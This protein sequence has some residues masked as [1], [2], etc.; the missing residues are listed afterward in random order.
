M[1]SFN[2]HVNIDIVKAYREV[3]SMRNKFLIGMAALFIPFIS[4]FAANPVTPLDAKINNTLSEHYNDFKD[5][6]YFSGIALA[7][8]MPGQPTK[9]YYIGNVG[10]ESD[11]KKMDA[12]TL[13]EIGSIT[14]S[15]TAAIILQLEKENKLH[16]SDKIGDHLPEYDKW[17]GLKIESLL[18]M[19]TGLPNYTDSPL[20]NAE[21]YKNMQKAWTDKE[22]IQYAYPAGTFSPPLR[23][24][25]FYCIYCN[26]G[27][28][29]TA[30][31]IEK[32]TKN[33]FQSEI[34]NRLIKAAKLEN[35]FYPFPA[36]NA[37]VQA[38]LAHGY[39]YNPYA[40]P[41]LVG[42]DM[43]DNNLSWAGAA[44][45]VIS[46]PEDV[47]K[48]V[49]ALFVGNN[50][51]NVE[52][53]SKLTRLNSTETGLPIKITSNDEPR[54]FGLGVVQGFDKTVGNF[55]F[56]EGETTGFRA[57]YMYVPSNGIIISAIFNSA[58]DTE[59]DHAG[60]LLNQVYQLTK[61]SLPKSKFKTK[62]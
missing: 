25:Y 29:L 58:V 57:L 53:K 51:L 35:T 62:S 24:G 19:T 46:N 52:Q 26:T 28:I 18:N 5:K 47:I 59:N 61:A 55:W 20:V 4:S 14:K 16:L 21:D 2:F 7:V 48:W 9:N 1:H 10:H 38:R 11:S 39:G 44:G 42:K 50:I 37:Q 43:K 23:S 15:F 34:E 36:I 17:A 56:Y 3:D 60:K 12:D 6:E 49:N 8:Y 22:L 13:F 40:N 41:E 32:V 54:G 33:T 45:A 31:M 30:M 27:Y